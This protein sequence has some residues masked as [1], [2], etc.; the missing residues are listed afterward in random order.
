MNLNEILNIK[1]PIIQGGMAWIATGKFAAEVSNLGAMGLI[2]TG[3]RKIED[4]RREIEIAKSLTD[5]PFGLNVLMLHRDVDKIADLVLEYDIAFVSTGAGNPGK[6]I[7]KWKDNGTKV[8]PVVASKA[9]AIR[10]ERAGA[11]GLICEGSEAGGHI[12][13]LTS[14]V[15]INEVKDAVDIPVVLAGGISN[16]RTMLAADCLGACGVQLG[17]I[18]LGSEECPIHEN[19]KRKLIKSK[20]SSV[21]VIGRINGLPTRVIKNKMVKDYLELEKNGASLE[22]LEKLTHSA[23]G[24]AVRDGDMEN[25]S[26]MAGQAVDSIKEIRPL[27]EIFENLM[28]E[29]RK[30]KEKFVGDVKI[31]SLP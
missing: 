23:L 11:D 31:W 4:I 2:A 15:L 17:T 9:L 30:E 10:L 20:S 24:R 1:Y 7:K 6:Y 25:G 8:F 14:L 5:K 21:K 22:E 13:E 12:G 27:K 26:I 3:G 18:L 19:Y 29:Y 28:D 16:G